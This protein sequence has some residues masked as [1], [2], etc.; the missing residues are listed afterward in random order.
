MDVK[1]NWNSVKPGNKVIISLDD[2]ESQFLVLARY[3]Q[4]FYLYSDNF[5]EI[6]FFSKTSEYYTIRG[7]Y[8][9][10]VKNIEDYMGKDIVLICGYSTPITLE[11]IEN[12]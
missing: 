4:M 3:G 8:D 1:M 9:E 5:E 6:R 7:K 11:E 12:E 2:R 10:T